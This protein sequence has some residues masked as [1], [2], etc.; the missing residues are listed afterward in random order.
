M[1]LITCAVY[2]FVGA[3]LFALPNMTRR[4][5][6]F[7]VPVPSDFRQSRAGRHAIRMFRV[8][9]VIAVLAGIGALLLS[10][11]GVLTFTATAVA[12]AIPLA[13]YAGFYWQNR[14]L[15]SAAV[16]YARRR[17]TE[18][19]A[20]PEELPRFAWL[21][22]GPFVILA[23]TARWLF[24]NWERIP[25]RFPNHWG[26]NGQPDH[27][28]PPEECTATCSSASSFAYWA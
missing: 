17:E 8:V 3:L 2:V 19:T 22:V 24:L 15:A 26:A 13:G 5:L 10:P 27:W 7:A 23:A 28:G 4:E 9:V 1:I 21:A 11:A 6:L 25:A 14:K 16:Q 18:L 12:L 20:A